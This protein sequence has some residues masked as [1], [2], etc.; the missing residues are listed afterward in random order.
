MTRYDVTVDARITVRV[1]ADNQE[2]A[3]S[4][5]EL[6]LDPFPDGDLVSYSVVR[7]VEV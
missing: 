6:S 2:D 5:A 3:V 7:V 1:D 4:L